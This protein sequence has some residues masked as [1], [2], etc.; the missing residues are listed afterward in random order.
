[1]LILTSVMKSVLAAGCCLAQDN[2][3]TA[4]FP[5]RYTDRIFLVSE[6]VLE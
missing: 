2:Y 4:E 3:E 5:P 1:M 6:G